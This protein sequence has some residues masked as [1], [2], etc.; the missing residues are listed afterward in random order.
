MNGL[1]KIVSWL[2]WLC[3]IRERLF[4]LSRIFLVIWLNRFAERVGSR[5]GLNPS[6]RNQQLIDSLKQ[7]PAS[8]NLAFG[9]K[10][11]L[12]DIKINVSKTAITYC[13]KCIKSI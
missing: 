8:Y 10:L 4:L 3:P 1:R 5:T 7:E 11:V 13:S 6:E 9:E 2:W 12:H